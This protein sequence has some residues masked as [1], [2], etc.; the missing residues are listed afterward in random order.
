MWIFIFY[1][2]VQYLKYNRFQLTSQVYIFFL[3]KCLF[4]VFFILLLL[5]ETSSFHSCSHSK[6]KLTFLRPQRRYCPAVTTAT[7]TVTTTVRF[8]STGGRDLT[9]RLI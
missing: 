5:L 6:W 7:V 4:P 1:I 8:L 3:K 2:K 9:V